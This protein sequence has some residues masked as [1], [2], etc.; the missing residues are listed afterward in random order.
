MSRV[1]FVNRFYW[2][3]HAA[4]GQLL[5]DL[6]EGMAAAGRAVTVITSRSV[7][8][9]PPR[10][11]RAGVEVIRTSRRPC[12]TGLAGKATAFARFAAGA[13]WAFWRSARRGDVLVV[14]TD[15]PLLAVPLTWLARIKGARVVHWI[16]D[17]YPEIAVA[18]T[19]HAWLGAL[20]PLRNAAWRDA[21]A[22]VTLGPAMA[23]VVQAAGVADARIAVIPNWAPEEAATPPADAAALRA[24]WGLNGEFVVA[25]AGNLGRVHDVDSIL[26]TAELL[27]DQRRIAFAFV[28]G[29]AQRDHVAASIARLKLDN[30]RLLPPQPRATLGAALAVGD[31]H[32]VT[33]RP[34]CERFVFPSKVYGICAARRPVLFIGPPESDVARLVVATG[35][36]RAVPAGN[37][38][39]VAS[40]VV[41]FAADAALRGRAAEAA[42]QFAATSSASLAIGRWRSLLD[43]LSTR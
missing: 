3:D 23:G 41:Q 37:P 15:P 22:C 21:D 7:A 10:E 17:I 32:L 33:L 28:G 42:G 38:V 34:G 36:G 1:I 35:I 25:Y 31:L 11:R 43:T 13:C 19:G 18:V 2:P 24:V 30:V 6:A 40:A 29:G 27:R 16:H 9:S 39:A 8:A 14:L 4:T 26:A 5:T 12:E 20:R